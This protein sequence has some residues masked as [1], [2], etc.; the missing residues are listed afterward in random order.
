MLVLCVGSNSL[1]GK[2]KSCIQDHDESSLLANSMA[3]L[4]KMLVK[5]GSVFAMIM[6]VILMYH[7]IGEAHEAK[8]SFLSADGV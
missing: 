6:F 4:A 2:M 5:L 3:T 1:L 7:S 8:E